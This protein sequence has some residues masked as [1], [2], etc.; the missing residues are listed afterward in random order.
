LICVCVGY[1]DF[2][3]FNILIMNENVEQLKQTPIDWLR[4]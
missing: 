1:R 4:F 3:N 2:G